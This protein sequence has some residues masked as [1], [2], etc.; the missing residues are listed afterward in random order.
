[1]AYDVFISYGHEDKLVADA[2]CARLEAAGIR[3]WIAPRNLLPGRSY[4]EGIADALRECQAFVLVFSHHANLSR[5]VANEVERAVHNNLPIVPLRIQDIKPSRSLEYFIGSVHWLDALTPPLEQHLEHLVDSIQRLTGREP[6]RASLPSAATPG[7][8][9]VRSKWLRPAIGA[10]AVIV[11]LLA[12]V[13]G[14][15][16]KAPTIGVSD[17]MSKFRSGAYGEALPILMDK[18]KAG[19]SE[20]QRA[21]GEMYGK[22]MGVGVNPT[23]ARS[24]LDKAIGQGDAE[25]RCLLADLYRDGAFGGAEPAKARDLYTEAAKTQACGH[26]GIGQL[27]VAAARS[28]GSDF[29]D[30]LRHLE[31]AAEGGDA[32]AAAHIRDLQPGWEL[33]PLVP[34]AWQPVTSRERRDEIAQ[35]KA[36]KI[37]EQAA[38]VDVRRLRR[39]PV[40]FYPGTTLFELEVGDPRFGC[41]VASY[42]KRAGDVVPVN[43]RSEQ[44]KRFNTS[45]PL[46]IETRQKAA[47]F[48]R[49]FQAGALQGRQGLMRVV[50]DARELR[51]NTQTPDAVKAST[52]HRLQP[53][54]LA[55]GPSGGWLVDATVAYGGGLLKASFWLKP[56]G[57]IDLTGR[58]EIASAL[59]L[60]EEF[61]DPAGVRLRRAPGAAQR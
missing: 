34:G 28:G 51:W 18:A 19:S 50:E 43:G 33:E 14:F 31:Q 16:F 47:A 17:G 44:I 13:A 56:D 32:L 15:L 36:A 37:F 30:G 7:P 20:A 60:F 59:P 39:L 29:D 38:L 40:E 10:A 48:L 6:L 9:P 54:Q 46:Q 1:M 52:G 2:A 49:F 27:L 35:V 12:G 4:G 57:S 58:E 25:A 41:G 42:L 24:W 45:A 53:L 26:R 23:E 21:L 8:A 61:F 3:C 22:G 55:S 5:H 11:V